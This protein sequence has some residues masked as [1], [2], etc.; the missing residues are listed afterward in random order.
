MTS[1]RLTRERSN[2]DAD[3]SARRRRILEA[4]FAA[5]TKS[6]YA[7][8]STLEI[9]TRAHVSKRALYQLFSSKQ[10]MLAAC[11]TERARRLQLPAEVPSARDRDELLRVLTTIGARLL[12]EVSAPAVIAVFRLAIAEAM[13]APEVAST[14]DSI[15]RETSRAVLR[16]IMAKAQSAG[17]V[18]GRPAEMAEQFAGL[19][20]GNLIVSLLLCVAEQPTEKEI[21][22]RAG[23]AAAGFLK[24]YD[25][26][27]GHRAVGEKPA[28]DIKDATDATAR[29]DPLHAVKE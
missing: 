3:N 28:A 21:A 22:R 15:G 16:E 10:E 29:C 25:R 13:G 14:L 11:I 24:L 6:G 18:D 8:T 23:T 20:W 26:P 19:L 2:Q 9:A 5:F 12:R 27:K 17:L 7:A 4:A 1:T